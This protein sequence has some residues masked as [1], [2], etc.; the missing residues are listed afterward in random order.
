MTA[1]SEKNLFVSQVGSIGDLYALANRLVSE[2]FE[3]YEMTP[4][5]LGGTLIVEAIQ[6]DELKEKS[7]LAVKELKISGKSVCLQKL[8]SKI[9]K[10]YHSLESAS[11]ANEMTIIE[12]SF[13][14]DIFALAHKNQELQIL[15]LRYLRSGTGLS[16]LVTQGI[17]TSVLKDAETMGLRVTALQNIHDKIKDLFTI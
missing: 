12:G 11:P 7:E 2:G 4:T 1:T 13:L 14:G 16:Y 17:S 8:S 3:I 9:L 5:T 6:F 15:D 10:A